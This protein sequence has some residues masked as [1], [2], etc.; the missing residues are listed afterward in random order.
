MF[1]TWPLALR[2]GGDNTFD[3]NWGYK[4]GAIYNEAQASISP[5]Q[6]GG[7]LVFENIRGT[8]SAYACPRGGGSV[9]SASAGGDH[10]TRRS[11]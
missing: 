5:P 3:D 7:D 2:F 6:D 1:V 8:V 11:L 10:G 4:G 9:H